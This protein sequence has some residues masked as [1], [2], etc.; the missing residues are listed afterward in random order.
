MKT[1]NIRIYMIAIGVI[2]MTNFKAAAQMME[3]SNHLEIGQQVPK[4]LISQIVNYKSPTA[5]LSDFY[6]G[7]LLIIDFWGT[8]CAPCV[9]M[10]PKTDSLEKIFKG[11]LEFLLVS[12][13]PKEKV[14]SFID[15]MSAIRKIRPASVVNDKAINSFFEISTIPYYAWINSKGE[16]IATSGSEEITEENIAAAMEGE[17]LFASRTD[18]ARKK[19]DYK[20]SV[21][22][23]SENLLPNSPR[24]NTKGIPLGDIISFS[25]ATGYMED[26]PGKFVFDGNH[27]A[28]VNISVGLLYRFYY[29]LGYY[30]KPV[31]GAFASSSRHVFEIE[32]PAVFDRVAFKKGMQERV[33]PKERVDWGKRNGVCYEIF[34][35]RNLSWKEKM[36]L[37]KKDLDRYFADRIGFTTKVQ[38]RIDSGS[39]VL[40][41]SDGAIKITSAGGT[42]KEEHNRYSYIQR[43]LPITSFLGVVKGYFFQGRPVSLIN[44]STLT[45]NLDLDLNCD[46]SNLDSINKALE[47]YGLAF[48][49]ESNEI[50]VLVFSEKK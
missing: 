31:R 45:D 12:K 11:K 40:R 32:D 15:K 19:L 50:D 37:V 13:E 35:P 27:L 14:S 48:I 2:L 6:D 29:D 26:G 42:P 46:M 24:N 22:S 30:D 5:N 9:A 44:K 38:K 47:R 23:L 33:T 34:Y 36:D 39:Y 8:W 7:K 28:A 25:A 17:I 20:K 43:N 4:T 21:F 10:L 16:L 1:N 41:R 3:A 49:K 18:K